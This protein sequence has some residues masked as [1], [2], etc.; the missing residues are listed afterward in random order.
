[1]KP[2]QMPEFEFKAYDVERDQIVDVINI[3][4]S[5]KQGKDFLGRVHCHNG[6]VYYFK[7]HLAGECFL[8]Q[9]T[10]QTD[11]YKEKLFLGDLVQDTDTLYVIQWNKNQTA[12][13]LNPL[14]ELNV[15]KQDDLSFMIHM[16]SQQLGNG[17]F[18]R[19]DLTK[20]GNWFTD[21]EKFGLE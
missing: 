8:L 17:Y 21:K 7:N 6:H 10:G 19:K 15:S 14:K 9:Y 18:S 20:V 11:M 1:M 16:N 5:D 4:T 2:Y 12:Y 13:W 3:D